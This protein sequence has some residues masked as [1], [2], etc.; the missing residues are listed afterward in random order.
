VIG[1]GEIKTEQANDG[2]DQPLGLA[3]REAEDGTQGSSA[4]MIAS[5]E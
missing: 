5:A 3:Q 1:N 2:V 4:V